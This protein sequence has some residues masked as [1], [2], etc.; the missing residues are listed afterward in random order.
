MRTDLN[1]QHNLN[2]AS[3]VHHTSSTTGSSSPSASN[4][5]SSRNNSLTSS[6]RNSGAGGTKSQYRDWHKAAS[7]YVRTIKEGR[8]K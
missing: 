8:R 7:S 2:T 3:N 1:Q 4:L 6:V 5:N